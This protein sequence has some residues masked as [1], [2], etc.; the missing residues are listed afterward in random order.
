MA[1]INIEDYNYDGEDEELKISLGDAADDEP[2]TEE[3]DSEREKSYEDDS[4]EFSE[5]YI[6]DEPE[7]EDEEEEKETKSDN[8]KKPL[9]K[10]KKGKKEKKDPKDAKIEELNDKLLRLMAEYENYRKRTDKEKSAMFEMGA[11]AIVE[12]IIPV[13][14]NFERGF[15]SVPEE[16][17][18]DP[19]YQG[20]DKVYEQFMSSLEEAGVKP[21]EAVGKEFD[22]NMHN[23]IMHVDDEELGDNII[24]EEFQKGY[25]Y[26][27]S[28]V[29]YSMVKVAN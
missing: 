7:E 12:R 17:K 4:D 28:V 20:M 3:D 27:D 2:D 22:P 9:F 24:V 29:R 23:A 16:S 15:S 10:G 26:K 14:D 5:E 1:E 18:D 19:F 21:I 8:G 6:E 11:K 13:I 25:T